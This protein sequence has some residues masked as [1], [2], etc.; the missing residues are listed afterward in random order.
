MDKSAKIAN[1]LQF[2]AKLLSTHTDKHIKQ[3]YLKQLFLD[4]TQLHIF[5]KTAFIVLLTFLV[6]P[7][8]VLVRKKKKLWLWNHMSYFLHHDT[9]LSQRKQ[10]YISSMSG[11]NVT[12]YL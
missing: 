1:L 4:W 5:S 3:K 10:F 6:M 9:L 12:A 8:E 11:Q 7:H 2:F